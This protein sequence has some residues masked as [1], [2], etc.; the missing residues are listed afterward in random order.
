ML[1]QQQVVKV[2]PCQV[3]LKKGGKL[4]FNPETIKAIQ[5]VPGVEG[6]GEHDGCLLFIAGFEEPFWL[7]CSYELFLERANVNPQK[8]E[9]PQRSDQ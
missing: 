7:A 3:Y 4:C 1:P 9:E 5:E 2:N 8:I 6:S